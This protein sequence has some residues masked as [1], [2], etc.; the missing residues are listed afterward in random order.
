MSTLTK[1]QQ[2]YIAQ[3]RDSWEVMPEFFFRDYIK[4]F[5][6][7]LYEKF[8]QIQKNLPET[9]QIM[10]VDKWS[11]VLLEEFCMAIDDK[12]FNHMNK[13]LS[14]KFVELGH[15]MQP[16][17]YIFPCTD[18]FCPVIDKDHKCLTSISIPALNEKTRCPWV[19]PPKNS[20]I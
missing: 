6:S 11:I 14:A 12:L 20:L 4:E 10:F 19:A 17:N 15:V 2:K 3:N 16:G 13:C 18:F 5:H 9:Y 7:K 1:K 8:Y